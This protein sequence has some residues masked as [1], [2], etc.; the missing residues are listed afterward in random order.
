M[1]EAMIVTRDRLVCMKLK[2][3][4]H[5][6]L[7][8]MVTGASTAFLALGTSPEIIEQLGWMTL[9]KVSLGAAAVGVASY[10]K[11]SPLPGK[12]N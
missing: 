3:W 10:L 2:T 4:L 1:E 5:G 6:L 8:A 9:A 7:G 11:Q 12:G